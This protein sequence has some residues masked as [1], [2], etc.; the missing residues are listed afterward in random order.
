MLS[1]SPV[2]LAKPAGVVVDFASAKPVSVEPIQLLVTPAIAYGHLD[3]V[4]TKLHRDYDH[5]R[6]WH[7]GVNSVLDTIRLSRATSCGLDALVARLRAIDALRDHLAWTTD[8]CLGSRK[9]CA[10]AFAS[11]RRM[12]DKPSLFEQ[13]TQPMPLEQILEDL[14]PVDGALRGRMPPLSKRR[15]RIGLGNL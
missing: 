4:V 7:E 13:M 12:A 6:N 1:I 8:W 11:L 3:F 5:Y 9:A 14:A 15:V 10:A 2:S